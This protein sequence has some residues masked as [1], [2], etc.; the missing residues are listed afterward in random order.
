MSLELEAS[1]T[2]MK[3]L[4]LNYPRGTA[5]PTGLCDMPSFTPTQRGSG[6]RTGGNSKMTFDHF[7]ANDSEMPCLWVFF[8][9]WRFQDSHLQV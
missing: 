2:D 7:S 6:Q 8:Y 9:K 4:S 3:L 5:Q 1:F